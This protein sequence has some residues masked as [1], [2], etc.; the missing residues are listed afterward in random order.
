MKDLCQL[1]I[2]FFNHGLHGVDT[3]VTLSGSLF[4]LVVIFRLHV[5]VFLNFQKD[6]LFI[7]NIKEYPSDSCNSD[8]VK[9]RRPGFRE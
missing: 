7:K 5:E 6:F 9:K 8:T 1:V 2:S 3:E 4:Q